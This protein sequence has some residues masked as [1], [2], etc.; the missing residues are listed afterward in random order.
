MVDLDVVTVGKW[1]R[2]KNGDS[3]RKFIIRVENGDFEMCTP[4]IILDLISEWKHTKLAMEIRE[5]YD[6]YSTDFISLINLEA[7]IAEKS[8]NRQAITADLK[9]HYIKDEDIIINN[10]LQKHNL[11]TIKIVS[12]DEI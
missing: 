5:F 4:Y 11:R 12:P 7:K 6:I 8:V 10:E 9:S 2:G 1:D 3:G